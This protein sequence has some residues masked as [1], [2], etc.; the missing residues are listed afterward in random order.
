MLLKNILTTCFCIGIEKLACD[1]EKLV[2]ADNIV[3]LLQ[4]YQMYLYICFSGVHVRNFTRQCL[5]FFKYVCTYAHSPVEF[6]IIDSLHAR[7]C[8]CASCSKGSLRFFLLLVVQTRR[9]SQDH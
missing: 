9:D 5:R 3:K 1:T 2:R 8:C 7:R 6:K 4:Q